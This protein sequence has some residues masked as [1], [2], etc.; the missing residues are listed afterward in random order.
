VINESLITGIFIDE[1]LTVN[2]PL[3]QKCRRWVLKFF[4]M[5]QNCKEYFYY[6]IKAKQSNFG[7]I[8]ILWGDVTLGK[9]FVW[10]WVYWSHKKNQIIESISKSTLSH[11]GLHTSGSFHVSR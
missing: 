6:L 5:S 7:G 9:M 11:N 2:S 3:S 10:E 8:I 4:I 1:F